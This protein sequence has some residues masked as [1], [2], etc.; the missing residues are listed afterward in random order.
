MKKTKKIAIIGAGISGLG[1]AWML[2]KSN[3]DFV[4]FEADN[5][6][7]GHCITTN[8]QT[9]Q[10]ELTLDLGV[11]GFYPPQ[12][13]N[14]MALTDL[15]DIDLKSTPISML[16]WNDEGQA[17]GSFLKNTPLWKKT[18]AEKTRFLKEMR[19]LKNSGAMES[20]L[21]SVG[22]YLVA[23]NYSKDFAYKVL[24][25][26][27]NLA[28]DQGFDV[29]QISLLICQELFNSGGFS[30]HT[31]TDWYGWEGTSKT[32]YQALAK[33]FEEKIRLNCPIQKVIRQPDAVLLIDNKGEKHLFDEVVFSIETDAI[34]KILEQPTP[35]EQ[36]LFKR[37]SYEEFQ[38]VL[39]QDEQILC[40][41]E[42]AQKRTV[43]EFYD[44][45][46]SFNLVEYFNLHHYKETFIETILSKKSMAKINPEKILK[47][48]D[49][50]WDSFTPDNLVNKGRFFN[51]QGKNKTWYC[52]Y[53]TVLGYHEDCLVSGM[54][55][56]NALGASYPFENMMGP[57]KI[58]NFNKLLMLE[59]ITDYYQ[60]S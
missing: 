47:V 34:L 17:W 1:T 18:Q 59:G 29:F 57:R 31:E 37:I 42:L 12:Y 4:L 2:E 54:V 55:I 5:R 58:F 30:F 25:P 50:K 39:H 35:E 8:L 22:D 41:I 6:L 11:L 49:F 10:G 33:S 7:G 23:Q 28:V 44:E 15:F 43:V 45:I 21:Q 38:L 19:Q 46:H 51:V 27:L 3:I 26:E 53:P 13:P 32:F 60:R 24:A 36:Q 40:P 20:T 52:G 14:L 56:A 16:Y 9:S 48:I